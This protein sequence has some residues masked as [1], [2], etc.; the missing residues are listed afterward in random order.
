MGYCTMAFVQW[1]WVGAIC[2]GGVLLSGCSADLPEFHTRGLKV[3]SAQC[4]VNPQSIGEAER[5]APFSKTN[6]C[7]IPNP[8]K[9]RSISGVQLRNSATLNCGMVGQLDNWINGV[10]QPAARSAFGERITSVRVAASY[11]CRARD[12]KRGAKLSEHGL[13]NA[14]DLSSFTLASGRVVEVEDGWRGSGDE[15]GF[16][17]RVNKGSCGTFT[18]VLGPNH[19]R[20]HRNHFHLDLAKHGRNGTGRYCR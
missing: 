11:A 16:L 3:P 14:I 19:N 20:A 8:W 7:G 10:A 2:A 18:T 4:S 1:R 13:G 5:L 12:N 6:G 17:R 15:R 9:M